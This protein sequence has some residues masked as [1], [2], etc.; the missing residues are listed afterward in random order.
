MKVYTP[1]KGATGMWANTVFNDG[2]GYT[3]NEN[4]IRYFREHGY[5]VEEEKQTVTEQSAFSD[6]LESMTVD[7]LRSWLVKHGKGSQIKNIRNKERLLNIA[8]G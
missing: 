5:R 2:V 7:Q 3:D 4:A 6:D 8:R 1:V